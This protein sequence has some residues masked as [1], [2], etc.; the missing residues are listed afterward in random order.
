MLV[1]K[2]LV[3]E[4]EYVRDSVG[5]APAIIPDELGALRHHGDGKIYTSKRAFSAATRALGLVEYGTEDPAKYYKPERPKGI[6]EDILRTY[7]ELRS[8]R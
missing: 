2:K 1:G 5:A 6:K 8:R 3:P 7:H 4:S